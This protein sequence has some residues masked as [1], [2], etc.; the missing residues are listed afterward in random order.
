MNRRNFITGIV[1][2]VATS[3]SGGWATWQSWFGSAGVTIPRKP[4][5]REGMRCYPV[6]S[7][8]GRKMAEKISRHLEDRGM[9]IVQQAAVSFQ[10]YDLN[11][12]E[13]QHKFVIEHIG[14]VLDERKCDFE[15][16]PDVHESMVRDGS[17]P[18]KANNEP[19]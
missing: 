12:I 17:Y 3:L 6:I 14:Y 11:K 16:E 8:E 7:D 19:S 2:G 4:E 1:A 5:Y 18:L 9:A 13:M 15:Y 10:G